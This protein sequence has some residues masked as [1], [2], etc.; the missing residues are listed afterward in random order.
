MNKELIKHL[1]S[2]TNLSQAELAKRVGISQSIISR[3]ENGTIPMQLQT[4]QK[5][6]Q[7]FVSEGVSVQDIALLHT[8]FES[9]KMK[10][11]GG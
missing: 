2:I 7:V 8:I 5:I 6:L 3:V 9:R 11:R 1:R 4:E 10:Q